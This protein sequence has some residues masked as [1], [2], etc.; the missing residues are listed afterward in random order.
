MFQNISKALKLFEKEQAMT[1]WFCTI[2][3]YV[4]IINFIY[5]LCH[6]GGI[7]IESGN[8]TNVLSVSKGMCALTAIT[9]CF[10]YQ[11]ASCI[12]YIKHNEFLSFTMYSNTK[13]YKTSYLVY[14][15]L[16][17][18]IHIGFCMSLYFKWSHHISAFSV[19]IAFLISRYWSYLNSNGKT[20]FFIAHEIYFIPKDTNVLVWYGAYITELVLMIFHFWWT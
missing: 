18:V 2:S 17:N 9:V 10:G 5:K 8:M 16:D 19:F 20:I 3:I 4:I 1:N 11:M 13:G 7:P 15:L 6:K 14:C 12:Y